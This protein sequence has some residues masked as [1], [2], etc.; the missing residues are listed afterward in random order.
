MRGARMALHRV[1]QIDGAS[2]ERDHVSDF[3]NEN[4][5]RVLYLERSTKRARDLVKRIGFLVRILDL[6]VS[7]VAATLSGLGDI[8]FSQLER[9]APVIIS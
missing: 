1:V 9:H 5:Q 8:N 3:I 6:I 4:C 7:H 2:I